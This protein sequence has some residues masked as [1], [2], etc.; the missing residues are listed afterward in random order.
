[1]KKII[2]FD[3][4]RTIYDPDKNCLAPYV[5]F[6]L[7][8]LIRR[9]FTLYLISQANLSR[10]DLI[11]NLGI[12]QYFSKIIITKNKSKKDFERIVALK[13]IDRNASFVIGDRTRK[14]IR[15]GNSLG[16]QTI[17]FKAGKFANE[18]PRT[19]NEQP[20]YAVRKLKDVL[21]IIK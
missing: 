13:L 5:K 12:K 19:K 9:G 10:E 16:L 11:G 3:F 21:K 14:E 6:I 15:I 20:K 18:K 7:R 17:W 2:I 1:M 8:I 4:N